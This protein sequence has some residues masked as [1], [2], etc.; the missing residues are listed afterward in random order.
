MKMRWIVPSLAAVT[1][2]NLGCP[3]TDDD[4]TSSSSG[5]QNTGSSSYGASSSSTAGGSSSRVE[6]SSG[7]QQSSSAAVSG[8]SSSG[9]QHSSS[10]AVSSTTSS[11]EQH[12]SSATETSSSEQGISSSSLADSSSGSTASSGGSQEGLS[13][14]VDDMLF[15]RCS[16]DDGDLPPEEQLSGSVAVDFSNS[17][18]SPVMATL[19]GATLTITNG[20]QQSSLS[21]NLTWSDS[22]P[23]PDGEIP[24]GNS[25]A[26]YNE[27][28][29]VTPPNPPLCDFCQW[30]HNSVMPTEVVEMTWNVNGQTLT[31]SSRTTTK[32]CLY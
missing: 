29:L 28:P 25:T 1:L 12:S 20:G 26:W 11:G 7:A 3:P 22:N 21:I 4:D 5:G 14:V 30:M 15:I 6:S 23:G 9:A 32:S 27:D 19:T 24:A 2:L 8:T 13:A 17:A 10:A 16:N 18:D 31:A